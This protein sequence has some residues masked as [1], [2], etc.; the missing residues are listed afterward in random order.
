M[1]GI[2]M[3][4]THACLTALLVEGLDLR[5]RKKVVVSGGNCHGGKISPN[6]FVLDR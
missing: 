2:V 3:A 6:G 1:A 5:L 4:G